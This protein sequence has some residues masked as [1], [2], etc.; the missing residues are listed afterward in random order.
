MRKGRNYTSPLISENKLPSCLACHPHSLTSIWDGP[1]SRIPGGCCCV[2]KVLHASQTAPCR[3]FNPRTNLPLGQSYSFVDSSMLWCPLFW[4]AINLPHRLCLSNTPGGAWNRRSK[5]L[6][7]Y[8][9][10]NRIQAVSYRRVYLC[11]V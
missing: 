2:V 7:S 11:K 9:Q 6:F 8:L 10:I 4:Y 5:K 1:I 3:R